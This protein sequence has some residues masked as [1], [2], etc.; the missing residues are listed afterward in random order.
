MSVDSGNMIKVLRELPEMME[1]AL[2]L[3]DDITTPK[4]FVDNIVVIGM[5]GSG[6]TGDLLKVYLQDVP[7]QIHVI[8]DYTLPA[9]VSRKTLVFAI[10]YSGNTEETVSAYRS[11]IRRG[12]KVI[13]ICSGGKLEELSEMNNNPI[14][15]VPS[16]IQPRLSTPFLFL[17]ILN[18]LAYSGVIDNNEDK[19]RKTISQLKSNKDKIENAAKELAVKLKDKIPIIYSSQQI[20]CVAEKWKTDIN[21]NAKIHAFYN[22]W[23]EFNHNE[24][25]GYQ[26]M[27]GEFHTILLSDTEDHEKIKKRIKVFKN[28]AKKYKANLTEIAIT[29]DNFLTRL[30]TAI[31]M[32]TYTGYFLALEY[33]VDPTPVEIIENLKKELAK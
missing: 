1:K 27:T 32:G 10:S 4:E 15:K 11:A 7:V 30:F 17:P 22:T 9:F 6:F 24:I 8:K 3:G 16:G 5:G 29:G 26:N 20:F 23:S 19:I 31:W 14:V 12:C 28:L 2:T 13:A 25:C 18:I 21:E 33:N